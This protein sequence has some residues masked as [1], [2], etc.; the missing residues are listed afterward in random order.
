MQEAIFTEMIIM[1]MSALA[2]HVVSPQGK[3]F[4]QHSFNTY[5]KFVTSTDTVSVNTGNLSSNKITVSL[6]NDVDLIAHQYLYVLLPSLGINSD[7][8]KSNDYIARSAAVGCFS[9]ATLYSGASDGDEAAKFSRYKLTFQSGVTTGATIEIPL[10]HAHKVVCTFGAA[11][12]TGT[13]TAFSAVFDATDETITDNFIT[14]FNA[15]RLAHLEELTRLGILPAEA[16]EATSTSVRLVLGCYGNDA[17]LAP[18]AEDTKITP[19]SIADSAGE[20]AGNA[21]SYVENVGFKAI[22][23]CLLRCQ[24]QVLCRLTGDYMLAYNELAGGATPVHTL[25]M[26]G[27]AGQHRSVGPYQGFLAA[28]G[29]PLYIPLDFYFAGS[30]NQ[31]FPLVSLQYNDVKLEIV[32]EPLSNL[33]IVTSNKADV[34]VNGVIENAKANVKWNTHVEEMALVQEGIYLDDTTRESISG[35]GRGPVRRLIEDTQE[36]V[37]TLT[38]GKTV[39]TVTPDFNFLVKY[40]IVTVHDT[41]KDLQGQYYV[42][43]PISGIEMKLNSNRRFGSV[44]TT[45]SGFAPSMY[46]TLEPYL[47]ANRI[48][49][50]VQNLMILSHALDCTSYQP[51]GCCNMSKIQNMSLTVTF[52]QKFD[53]DLVLKIIAVNYNQLVTDNGTGGKGWHS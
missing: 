27:G 9:G 5:R 53:N 38:A 24:N 51:S 3:F 42:H 47:Y 11:A 14:A 32:L 31:A 23:S 46:T 35:L 40:W 34:S 28:G 16:A 50:K 19:D 49:S 30:Y 21:I 12:S 10:S 2:Q 48:P 33:I 8:T 45:V 4:F 13:L 22:Q 7:S 1:E 44:A 52:D 15:W 39:Y 36:H 26:T 25:A 17:A 29:V 43:E 20:S 6:P 37:E 41:Q 18:T